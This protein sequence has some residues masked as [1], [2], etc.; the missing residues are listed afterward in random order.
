MANSENDKT[1]SWRDIFSMI[2]QLVA[3]TNSFLFIVVQWILQNNILLFK[4]FKTFVSKNIKNVSKSFQ[5]CKT[6]RYGRSKKATGYPVAL[7][8]LFFLFLQL[9]IEGFHFLY[10]QLEFRFNPFHFLV[11]TIQEMIPLLGRD[12]E[13]AD[14]IFVGLQFIF[15]SVVLAH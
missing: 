12:G 8:L 13:E 6:G 14:I 15:H 4:Y 7:P 11:H 2:Q 9:P 1:M 3:Y 5:N 10:D